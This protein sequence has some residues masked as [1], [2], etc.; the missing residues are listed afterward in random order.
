MSALRPFAAVLCLLVGCGETW[1]V[2]SSSSVFSEAELVVFV[3]TAGGQ[4]SPS[5]AVLWYPALEPS[6]ALSFAIGLDDSLVA[7]SLDDQS[8]RRGVAPAEVRAEGRATLHSPSGRDCAPRGEVVSVGAPDE[9]RLR[10]RLD[11]FE[12]AS[13]VLGPGDD[14]LRRVD[15]LELPAVGALELE[16][17]VELEPCRAPLGLELR[18]FTEGGFF[19]NGVNLS[20][21]PFGDALYMPF[22][23]L[24]PAGD[25]RWFALSL[26]ALYHLRR[27]A[28]FDPDLDA[29][30]LITETG[31]PE[32]ELGRWFFWQMGV[33]PGPE[34]G[35]ARLLT[36]VRRVDLDLRVDA[37]WSLLEV[38]FDGR[39]F[40]APSVAW[41]VENE[42]G[43]SGA[44][45]HMHPS[46]EAAAVG[47][48]G[49][50]A[51]S[52]GTDEVVVGGRTAGGDMEAVRV[53]DDESFPHAVGV[54][55]GTLGLGDLASPGGIP[56]ENLRRG[57]SLTR[58]AMG[59][60]GADPWLYSGWKDG[61]LFRSRLGPRTRLEPIELALPPRLASCAGP[62]APVC[63]RYSVIGDTLALQPTRGPAGQELVLAL[64]EGCPHLIVH[65]VASGCTTGVTF[66]RASFRDFGSYS[67]QEHGGVIVVTDGEGEP[68]ELWSGP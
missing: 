63:G 68:L 54:R 46:G 31:L 5:Q 42:P 13:W 10:Q 33:R 66:P 59:S 30:L 38:R 55:G 56:S 53:L 39:A 64:F 29:R 17:P 51:V 52:K 11:Q 6:P 44:A 12:P 43:Q 3:P 41:L 26:G 19:P 65:E 37:G 32:I 16:L 28:P 9:T 20:G 24:W 34:P 50:W 15:E 60:D 2:F 57:S 22:R 4:P 61:H 21:Q 62:E 25:D 47:G 58:L 8:L 49:T 1:T 23:D 67:L 40:G 35:Q 45:F 48:G 27:G 14:T 7:L 18:P 36:M